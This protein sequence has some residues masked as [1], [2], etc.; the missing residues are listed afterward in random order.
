MENVLKLKINVKSGLFKNAEETYTAYLYNNGERYEEQPLRIRRVSKKGSA[1]YSND[2]N[3]QQKYYGYLE[4]ADLKRFP[5]VGVFTENTH[6]VT[7]HE[8]SQHKMFGKEGQPK[9]KVG[10]NDIVQSLLI[11]NLSNEKVR[12][13]PENFSFYKTEEQESLVGR[14]A[15]LGVLAPT[16]KL[17]ELEKNQNQEYCRKTANEIKK[18]HQTITGQKAEYLERFKSLALEGKV[19]LIKNVDVQAD[20]A[21]GP[22][23]KP[24]K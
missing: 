10:Q 11:I 4:N 1:I 24:V 2:E 17:I 15:K 20:D 23:L 22:E 19:R 5:I 14:E 18:V 8:V 21:Q 12:N 7:A 6:V 3:V 16:F 9:P 13:L